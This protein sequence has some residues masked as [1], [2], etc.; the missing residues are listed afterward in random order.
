MNVDEQDVLVGTSVSSTPTRGSVSKIS[1]TKVSELQKEIDSL[2]TISGAQQLLIQELEKKST[3]HA[4]TT[5]CSGKI[6][7]K[8][9]YFNIESSLRCAQCERRN[10]GNT[11]NFQEFLGITIKNED[12]KAYHVLPGDTG[13]FLPSLLCKFIYFEDKTQV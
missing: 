2:K 5:A 1:D 6:F 9:Q 11:K 10:N 7:K 4:G 3:G 8:R 12:V 13:I